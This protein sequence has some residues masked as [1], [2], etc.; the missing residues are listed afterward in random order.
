[1]ARSFLPC[2]AAVLLSAAPRDY[3]RVVER[4]YER[5]AMTVT[6]TDRAGRPVPGLRREEF[7]ILEDGRSVAI[8]D[9][10]VEGERGD[11]P[12]SVAV[13]LDLSRSMGRQIDRIREA[14]LAL[15][16]TLRPGDEVLVARF[17]EEL[18]VL[19]PF[20][21]APED[22]GRTL[23]AIGT[24]RGGTAIFRSIGE[25]LR[26]LRER[27]GRKVVI[28]VTDGLDNDVE[29][30]G[31]VLSS[32]HLR[33]LIRRCA[34]TQTVVYG[35]R[36]GMAVASWMP[37][38]GFVTATGG[39][40]LYTGGD[41]ERLFAALGAEFRTQY[42]LA[43]D[44][45][46]KR[47][48]AGRLRVEVARGDLTVRAMS[49][50]EMGERVRPLLRA[51]LDPDPETRA[52]GV[53]DL[54]FVDDPRA[55]GALVGALRD[56]DA[57]VRRLAAAGLGRRRAVEAI[58]GLVEGL[59]DPVASVREAAG[60]ALEDLGPAALPALLG[61]PGGGPGPL[62]VPAILETAR[63][64]G[65]IGD[66]RA[67]GPLG[68]LLAAGGEAERIA[69]A[70]AL[71]RLGLMCGLPSLATALADPAREVR[72]E[73]LRSLVVIAGEAARPLLERYLAS[74]IDPALRQEAR[75]ALLSLRPAPPA[76]AP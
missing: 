30:S 70:R 6:V 74:E 16:K 42:Y 43:Y 5:V 55:V 44:R 32:L 73:T 13:L 58:P 66:D 26:D 1:M 40:L 61:A 21:S 31:H 60:R 71:G 52:D 47:R 64:L 53:Y 15:L 25:I 14:A 68:A 39:R 67:C 18:T 50:L 4:P 33:D 38:E 46:P 20:T 65:A 10:G 23:K 27:P 17:N 3:V 7:R 45:D 36:P 24:A 75:T 9:F 8:A 69:A 28:V 48:R 11:R 59:A 76:G 19:T 49:G 12:L 57:V 37:F 56:Q 22:P 51:A 34:R 35:V 2:L 54:G 41:L 29:R 72:S 62:P 63:L